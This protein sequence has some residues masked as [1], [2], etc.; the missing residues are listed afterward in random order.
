VAGSEER[1]VDMNVVEEGA[2]VA[3]C[4][5]AACGTAE[6]TVDGGLACALAGWRGCGGVERVDAAG[7]VPSGVLAD[8]RDLIQDGFKG[9]IAEE[10]VA[11]KGV[12]AEAE[13][14][15]VVGRRRRDASSKSEAMVGEE[16]AEAVVEA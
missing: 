15:V 13:V 6:A 14:K 2:N 5:N 7:P 16:S 11:T 1:V 4:D 8:P 12:E 9:D 10:A 3:A